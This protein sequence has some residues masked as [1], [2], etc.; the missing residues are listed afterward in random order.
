MGFNTEQN[1][2]RLDPKQAEFDFCK[3]EDVDGNPRLRMLRLRDLGE[4]EFRGL[5][6]VPLREKEIPKD[7][8][9]VN[10]ENWTHKFNFNIFSLRFQ[11]KWEGDDCP[12]FYLTESSRRYYDNTRGLATAA[13]LLIAT[14]PVALIQSNL[15]KLLFACTAT[16]Q[17]CI[18]LCYSC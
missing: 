17:H 18:L 1:Y 3:M 15:D 2:F 14:K 4:P 5:R 9:K 6:V 16:L 13:V 7:V 12:K 8:F 10:L 11:S